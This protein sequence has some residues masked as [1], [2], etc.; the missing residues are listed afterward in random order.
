MLFLGKCVFFSSSDLV[1]W[2]RWAFSRGLRSMNFRVTGEGWCW[3]HGVGSGRAVCAGTCDPGCRAESICW[4]PGGPRAP[5]PLGLLQKAQLEQTCRQSLPETRN[6]GEP[7]SARVREKRR[8]ETAVQ[9][10]GE[11][12]CALGHASERGRWRGGPESGCQAEQQPSRVLLLTSWPVSL[13]L[14]PWL[15]CAY[16]G[17]LLEINAL[18]ICSVSINACI[19]N[20]EKRYWWTYLQGRN[21][22]TDIENGLVDT[23]GEGG[24]VDWESSTDL[25]TPPCVK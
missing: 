22:D 9:A 25:H 16:F 24:G 1:S 8:H 14:F 23:A 3:G 4:A 5:P 19:W 10:P 20:L 2:W 12:L 18:I 21:G 17:V 6:R 15:Y 11:G 7:E 13:S